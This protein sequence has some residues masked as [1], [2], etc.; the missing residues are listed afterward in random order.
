[1]SLGYYD[2]LARAS[3]RARRVGWESLAMQAARYR[4][5]SERVGVDESVLD[6]GAGLGDLGRHLLAVGHRGAYLGIER[7]AALLAEAARLEPRVAVEAG[8]VLTC[9][10]RADVVVA[11]GTLV[12]GTS[13]RDDGV[14]FGKLRRL[15]GAVTR[16][17]TRLGLIIVAQQEAIEARPVLASDPALGGMRQAELAWL[18]PDATL[19]ELSAVDWLVLLPAARQGS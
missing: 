4:A 13:L 11:L 7:D 12:D 14:R 15:V 10:H 9:E 5:V 6:L 1:M 8:D 3:D 18:A 19:V 17:R 16:A 2:E